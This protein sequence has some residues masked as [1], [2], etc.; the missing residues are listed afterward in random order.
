MDV[1]DEALRVR[2]DLT[3]LIHRASKSGHSDA[4]AHFFANAQRLDA[5]QLQ[6][7]LAELRI[8]CSQNAAAKLVQEFGSGEFFEAASFERLI[9]EAA[10]TSGVIKIGYVPEKDDIKY[11]TK[12]PLVDGQ[13]VP[14]EPLFPWTSWE[15]AE[16]FLYPPSGDEVPEPTALRCGELEFKDKDQFKCRR[17]QVF[18]NEL[19]RPYLA[20]ARALWCRV[21]DLFTHPANSRFVARVYTCTD[22]SMSQR[23][24]SRRRGPSSWA[25]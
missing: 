6:R 16:E 9:I 23:R 17:P 4:A 18:H 14:P 19:W 12:P 25:R 10:S 11:D 2:K 22:S 1:S 5:S 15:D 8:S 7:K 21:N 24:R 13:P 20:C 3:S